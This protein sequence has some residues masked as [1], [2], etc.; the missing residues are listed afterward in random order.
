MWKYHIY[1]APIECCVILVENF[2]LQC[3][4]PPLFSS[5]HSV[6]QCNVERP[7]KAPMI[8]APWIKGSSWWTTKISLPDSPR[9]LSWVSSQ[10]RSSS[11]WHF[12]ENPCILNTM[13]QNQ[14][15]GKE[16]LCLWSRACCIEFNSVKLSWK[17]DLPRL[18]HQLTFDNRQSHFPTTSQL[19]MPFF[20]SLRSMSRGLHKL[21]DVPEWK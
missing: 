19:V 6:P 9:T 10:K 2:L 21:C 14:K 8:V 11:H 15:G 12:P 1:F 17:L 4:G 18:Q 13:M 5:L 3:S 20:K 16:V 7:W